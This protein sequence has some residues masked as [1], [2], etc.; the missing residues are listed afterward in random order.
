VNDPGFLWAELQPQ[1]VEY[2]PDPLQRLLRFPA[3]AQRHDIV[4]VSHPSDAV[5]FHRHVQV[6]KKYRRDNSAL[7][8]SR[9]LRTFI[10]SITPDFR[11]P[12]IRS[13]T[14]R[15]IPVMRWAPAQKKDLQIS[16]ISLPG[17]AIDSDKGQNS[18]PETQ[19][20]ANL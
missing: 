4:G 9:R 15:P 6:L 1:P 14:F 2:L 16:R 20:L 13:R 12:R 11:K 17:S 3:P 10:S 19:V 18:A 5:C 7:R 8:R